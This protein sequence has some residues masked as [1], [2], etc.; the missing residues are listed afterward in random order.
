MRHLTAGEQSVAGWLSQENDP[1]L[2]E[3]VARL[4]EV[5]AQERVG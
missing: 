4:D 2:S 1:R 5:V 3:I